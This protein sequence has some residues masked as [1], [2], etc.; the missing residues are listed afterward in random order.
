MLLRRPLRSNA[1]AQGLYGG[2]LAGGGRYLQVGWER[3]S[4]GVRR[5]AA[6]RAVSRVGAVTVSPVPVG[7]GLLGGPS[8]LGLVVGVWSLNV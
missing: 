1:R 5:P 2:P 8:P 6:R 7:S 4:S 3:S